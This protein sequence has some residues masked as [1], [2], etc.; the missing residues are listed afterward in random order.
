M[1][2][3]D[4]FSQSIYP[5]ESL[6]TN[7]GGNMTTSVEAYF[8]LSGVGPPLSP[9]SLTFMPTISDCRPHLAYPRLL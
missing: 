2:V 1:F 3:H 6:V 5:S 4:G 7:F 8:S 9:W